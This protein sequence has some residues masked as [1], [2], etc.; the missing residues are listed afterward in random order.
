MKVIVRKVDL[1]SQMT[2]LEEWTVAGCNFTAAAIV[3]IRSLSPQCFRGRTNS[4]ASP[5]LL[6]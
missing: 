6:V 2:L 1:I 3:K 4:L 5:L